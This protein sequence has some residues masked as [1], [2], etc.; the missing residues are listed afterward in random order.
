MPITQPL[1]V[2]RYHPAMHPIFLASFIALAAFQPGKPPTKPAK[3]ADKPDIT[4]PAKSEP[5]K[6]A[7]AKEA[8]PTIT[9]VLYDVP[10]KELGDAD[11]DGTRN[12]T[13]DE[14]VELCNTSASAIDLRGY[15]LIDSDAWWFRTE[16]GK[17]T[18]DLR[19]YKADGKDFIFVFPECSL[20]A[21]Q[22]AVVFNGYNHTDGKP[23]P[24]GTHEKAAAKG[25]HFGGALVFSA[26]VKS[27]KAS[28]GNDGDWVA[29]VTPEGV[30]IEVVSW[31]KPDRAVPT[32]ATHKDETPASPRGSVER[33]AAAEAFADSSTLGD[34]SKLFTPGVFGSKAEGKKQE[35]KVAEKQPEVKAPTAKPPETGKK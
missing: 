12:A 23:G 16:E 13:G 14:F 19:R 9:E 6:P 11:Q 1:V 8:A 29:L 28:F 30:L 17:K 3:P 32:D 4:K 18:L 34:K 35:T 20:A 25:A 31:G 22:C 26:E 10:Q 2:I 24:F 21:G 33:M 5:A 7:A 27:A 15:A